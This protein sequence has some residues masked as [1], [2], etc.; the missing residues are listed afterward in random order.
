[1]TTRPHDALFQSVFESP[2][3][4]ASLLRELVPPAVQTAVAWNTLDGTRASFVDAKLTHRHGD[5]VFQA[6]LTIARSQRVYFV[7]EHQSTRDRTMPLRILTYQNRVWDRFVKA[8]PRARLAPVIGVL[9]SHVRGGWTAP[10]ALE[11]LFDPAV[12]ARPELAALVPRCSVVVGDL[13]QLSDDDLASRP[14]G[15]FAK[16]ALWL[17]RD[18]RDPVGLL[19]S[20]DRW[21]PSM[22]ELGRTRAGLAQL[23]VLITYMLEVIDPVKL[24]ALRAKIRTLGSGSEKVAMTIAQYLRNEGR[25]E[26]LRKGVEQGRREGVKEGIR[27]GRIDT[28]RS[29]LRSQLVLKFQTLGAAYEARLR[30][31]TPRELGRYLKRVLTADSLALVFDDRPMRH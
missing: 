13:A 27:R 19:D 8:H 23:K 16:L 17:L 18:A 25:R 10:R 14:L 20:F 9:V 26:G 21:I 2:A 1:M 22:L 24:D 11:E 3:A 5:L 15:T 7:V 30:A 29:T 6:R 12:M 31:A 4:A 28:L